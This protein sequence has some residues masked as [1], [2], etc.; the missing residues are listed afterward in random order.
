MSQV[1][2]MM[3]VFL[4]CSLVETDRRFRGVHCLYH[5]LDGRVT[6]RPEF[7]RAVLNLSFLYGI[8]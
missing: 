5:R 2:I 7:F 3:T 8:K 4:V 1:V 6:N